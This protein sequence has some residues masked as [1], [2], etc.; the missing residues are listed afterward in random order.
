MEEQKKNET[1]GKKKGFLARMFDKVDQKMKEK[2]SCCCCSS[3][4]KDTN[5]DDKSCCS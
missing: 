2:S 1:Q 3:Q 5:K 4:K